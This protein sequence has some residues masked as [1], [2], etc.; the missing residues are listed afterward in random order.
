LRVGLS[1]E[2]LAER[3]GVSVATIGSI[4]EGQRRH[5]Y[6]RTLRALVDAL[7]LN[8]V[9]AATLLEASEAE[10]PSPPVP[11]S[12][13]AQRAYAPPSA[14]LPLPP[15]RLVGRDAEVARLSGMLQPPQ[16]A[17]RLLTLVGPGGVGKTRLAIAVAA[18]VGPA[19]ADGVRFVDLATVDDAHLVA[20]AIVRALEVRESSGRTASEQLQLHLR[21]KQV[22]LLLDNFEHLRAAA[23]L[24]TELLASCPGLGLLVTSRSSLRVRGEHRVAVGPLG[25]PPLAPSREEIA[26]A[27]AVQLFVERAMAVDASFSLNEDNAGA[28][29][30]I[31]RRLEGVPLAL[32][33][34]AARVQLLTPNQLLRRLEHRLPTLVGGSA[35][36]PERQHTMRDALGWS[37]ELLRPA[38]Q[39]LFRRLS[40]FVGGWGLDAAESVCSDDRDLPPSQV[41]PGLDALLEHSLV[42]PAGAGREP[43]EPRFEMLE[44]VREY[45]LDRLRE[46]G[47]ETA[48]RARHRD[49]L[50][51]LVARRTP[52][53]EDPAQVVRMEREQGNLQAAMRWTI[54]RDE[55]ALG[56]ELGAG[57]WLFWYLRGRYTEGRSWLEQMLRLPSAAAP[58]RARAQAL[59]WA[60]HLAYCQGDHGAAGELLADGRRVAEQLGD[61]MSVAMCLHGQANVARASGDAAMAWDL[62]GQRL[63]LSQR[64]GD[65]VG[66]ALSLWGMANLS[67]EQGDADRA[68]GFADEALGLFR[69]EHYTWGIA[70][71]YFELGRCA[72]SRGDRH[73]AAAL[74][75]EALSIQ[76][77]IKDLQGLTWSLIALAHATLADHQVAQLLLREG[78]SLAWET[79]DQVSVVHGLEGTVLLT[80]DDE[81][82]AAVWLAAAAAAQRGR[83]HAA[84]YGPE[85]H[86]LELGVR[87]AESRLDAQA[88]ATAHAAGSAAS[89]TEAVESALRLLDT[90]GPTT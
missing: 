2:S 6:P 57:C 90:R 56:L 29:A 47:E 10:A 35:D 5:P 33:L 17:I 62:Y 25:I 3:S 21:D 51:G 81:P 7:E 49:W 13:P 40:V 45:A 1:Q 38:D 26:A 48:V 37:H 69:V 42:Q 74:L 66:Q 27:P 67:F 39:V 18:V 82:Q 68:R 54:E 88:L 24:L 86:R 19:C 83:L 85:A 75:T 52:L 20:A 22:L 89:V 79:G 55:G 32:E 58:T 50:L 44:T 59:S 8:P 14:E 46:S 4:E 53:S 23:P 65:R 28:I 16:P 11:T 12:E 30:A 43:T 31:C 80:A 60:G 72:N 41:L 9:E 63:A 73:S 34:A 71:A 78:L 76:R 77:N 84:P 15:T 61:D 64:L 36:M 87:A 70:R